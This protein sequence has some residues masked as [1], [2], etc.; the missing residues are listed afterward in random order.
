M[1]VDALSDVAEFVFELFG[2]FASGRSAQHKKRF[3]E[4]GSAPHL[5]LAKTI[6]AEHPSQASEKSK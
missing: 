4:A 5:P 3:V 2:D 6:Y 1:I